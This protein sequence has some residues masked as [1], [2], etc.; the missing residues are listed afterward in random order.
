MEVDAVAG[1]DLH[2]YQH[3]V[4]LIRI[5]LPGYRQVG[6][7]EEEPATAILNPKFLAPV[8]TQRWRGGPRAPWEMG[9]RGKL[10]NQR[11]QAAGFVS[12]GLEADVN[13]PPPG[14]LDPL[15]PIHAF[16]PPGGRGIWPGQEAAE[17][18]HPRRGQE[19]NV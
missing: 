10:N 9:S 8:D 18:A 12:A 16:P 11:L 3:P 13:F 2:F 1:R 14:T 19:R 4:R 17:F 6:F 5:E 7:S 15:T